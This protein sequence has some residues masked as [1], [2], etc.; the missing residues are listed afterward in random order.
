MVAVKRLAAAFLEGIVRQVGASVSARLEEWI[1]TR[2]HPR[3]ELDLNR[4]PNCGRPLWCAVHGADSRLV[5]TE[6]DAQ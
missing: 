5:E 3:R 4:C 1:E 6:A 2:R